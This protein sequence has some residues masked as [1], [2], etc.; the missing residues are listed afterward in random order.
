[1]ALLIRITRDQLFGPSPCYGQFH[2]GNNLREML[3]EVRQLKLALN[4]KPNNDNQQL[5]QQ[6]EMVGNKTALNTEPRPTTKQHQGQAQ[7]NGNEP[8]NLE[9]K[10]KV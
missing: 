1:M 7:L 8:T 10:F 2:W 6:Q 9:A 3:S 4:A 5:I